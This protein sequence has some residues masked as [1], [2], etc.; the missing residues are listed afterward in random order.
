[1]RER[2]REGGNESAKEGKKEGMRKVKEG[3]SRGVYSKCKG[4]NL[5]DFVVV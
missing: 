3:N 2:G 4:Q 1:M 5:R